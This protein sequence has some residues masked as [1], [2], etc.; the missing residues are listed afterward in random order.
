MDYTVDT[1]P[2]D[3]YNAIGFQT[4]PSGGQ[5]RRSKAVYKDI[6]TAFDIE[7]SVIPEINQ[8]VMY[9]WQMHFDG[10]GT[11]F[12][13]TWND[14]KRLIWNITKDMKKDQMLVVY[15]HNLSYEFQFLRGI[16]DFTPD[17]V[18]AIESRRI[19]KCSMFNKIEFRCSYIHS[20]MSLGLYTEKMNVEHKKLDGDD[21]DYSIARYWFTPLTSEELDYCRND[22]LGLVEAL[23]VEMEMDG[24]NLYTIPLT[25]TGYVRRDVKN[26]MESIN[27]K[28]L[29]DQL[30]EYEVYRALREAFRGG[31]THAN[32]YYVGEIIQ[33]VKSFDRSSSYPDV[34]CN[35]DFPISAFVEEHNMDLKKY[36]YLTQVAKRAVLTRVAIKGL[37]LIDKKWGC[38]YL[39][40]DK[41]RHI[42][43][44]INDNG[45]IL[46]AEYLE[47]TL[48]DIDLNII[49]QEYEFDDIAF[50]ATWSAKYGKL[51]KEVTD[52]IRYYYTKKTELKGIKDKEVF[53]AKIK[54][55]L[56]AVFGMSAQNPVKHSIKYVGVTNAIDP[57][58]E[59]EASDEQLL[60]DSNKKAFF[61]YA[62]GVWTTAWARYRLEEGIRLV[63]ET[64]QAIFL[65][66]DTDSVK[67]CGDVDWTEYNEERKEDSIK[68]GAFATDQSGETHYMGVYEP[69]GEYYE[70]VTLGAK[71]Y[72][73][74]K[75]KDGHIDATVSGVGKNQILKDGT[76]KKIGGGLELEGY[77]KENGKIYRKHKDWGL[78]NFKP[79]FIFKE[80][81]GNELKYNDAPVMKEVIIDNHRVVIG[82]NVVIKESTYTLGVSDE[83][84][85]VLKMCD[86]RGIWV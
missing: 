37:R 33:G 71:K 31:N 23:K 52:V 14:F 48:T 67:Y 46:E 78:E 81:G 65:Y 13:R 29:R 21:F 64:P 55:K 51:P 44:Y 57:F 75:K 20:N 19:M 56:N 58:I 10:I 84:A 77:V 15:V 1:F 26:S 28:W 40:L 27:K 83:Y 12:G 4:R 62:W 22:V 11:V 61:N 53:Y 50:I 72:A 32:R 36:I 79:G 73:Y 69:D 34:Q 18:F 42:S 43:E 63:H 49:I 70:F 54:A 41:V 66:T 16:Y 5:K 17:E 45:R 76:I 2:Y 9:V 3:K 7:T 68:S 30:P 25:S 60:E 35:C 86:S 85:R 47:T 74:R 82:P 59:A 80:S 39:S 24:D 8:A 6:I 38:P